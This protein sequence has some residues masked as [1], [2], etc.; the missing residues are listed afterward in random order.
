M[1]FI[2]SEHGEILDQ[3][4]EGDRIL[5]KKSIEYLNSQFDVGCFVKVPVDE[6]KLL[7]PE[8]SKNEK[9]FLMDISPYVGYCDCK[10]RYPNTNRDLTGKHLEQITGL[11]RTSLY[12]VLKGLTEKHI[13]H[14]EYHINP[15]VLNRG[16]EFDVKVREWFGDYK[17][18]S[19]G[20]VT[21]R[22]V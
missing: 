21:W 5:R 18:R 6:L 14:G 13:I 1:K 3:L 4:N 9:A 7:L 2:I 19:L 15:W 22:E 10:L 16:N 12:R 20:G 17:V 8:L 11:S